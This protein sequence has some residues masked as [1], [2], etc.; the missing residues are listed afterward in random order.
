[1][2]KTGYNEAAALSRAA[3]AGQVDRGGNDYFTAHVEEVVRIVREELGGSIAAAVVAYLH[4]VVEDTPVTIEEIET[5]FGAEI[6]GHVEAVTRK[7][8]ETYFEFIERVKAY[9]GDAVTV[10]TADVLDH[11]HNG[12]PIPFSLTER[13]AKALTMLTS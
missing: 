2:S 6:A 10:K 13:Y 7:E 3:H 4:D 11:L 8:S 12:N 1:M 5:K 9:G